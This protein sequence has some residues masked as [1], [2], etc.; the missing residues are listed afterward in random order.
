[1]YYDLLIFVLVDFIVKILFQTFSVTMETSQTST[2]PRQ[3][4]KT[5]QTRKICISRQSMGLRWFDSWKTLEKHFISQD[6]LVSCKSFW[7]WYEF[8]RPSAE[9]SSRCS[10]DQLPKS[11]S[12]TLLQLR[13]ARL[14]KILD[15]ACTG[16]TLPRQWTTK[17]LIG[18]CWSDCMDAQADLHLC[19]SHMTYSRFSHDMAQKIMFIISDIKFL[20]CYTTGIMADMR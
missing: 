8:C 6:M 14:L 13:L 16:I 7:F 10:S 18:L 19:C 15:L 1:M 3:C 9:M 20:F 11:V 2:T 4:I 5:Y 12:A 17:A